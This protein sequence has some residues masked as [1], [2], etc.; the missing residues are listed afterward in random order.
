MN[1]RIK[2]MVTASV[3][4]ADLTAAA[5]DEGMDTLRQM[6]IRKMLEGGTTYEEAISMAG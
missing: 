2:A 5:R 6:A 3:E 1:G 4:L